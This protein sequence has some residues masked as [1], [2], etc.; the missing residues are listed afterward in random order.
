[1]IEVSGDSALELV[2]DDDSLGGMRPFLDGDEAVLG[3]EPQEGFLDRCWVLH[4]VAVGGKKVR[5]EDVLACVGKRLEDWQHTPSFRVFGGFDLPEDLET[6]ELG[7][8]DRDSL[9]HLIEVLARHSPDG[10][11]T[12]CYWA[13]AAIEDIGR[14]VPARR[15]RL[16]EALAHY[17]A[18]AWPDWTVETQF[19]AHWWPLEGSWFV[20]TN[21]DLSAT[22]VF[23]TP[24]LIADLL[25][26]N[27]LDAVRHPSIAEVQGRFAEWREQA[28]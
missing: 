7:E 15:G 10:L 20:L 14:P 13:Q 16:D 17:D 1:M 4:T 23:G 8:I 28:K 11:R 18:C 21:W 26:D 22:E 9:A 25:A 24:A 5:W 19:P 27:R 6:P 3:Y 2:S 12:E